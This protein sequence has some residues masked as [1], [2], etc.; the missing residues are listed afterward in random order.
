ME[1]QS[2]ITII[3]AY[4]QIVVATIMSAFLQIIKHRMRLTTWFLLVM[5]NTMGANS[6]ARSD[7]HSIKHDTTMG[8]VGLVFLRLHHC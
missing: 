6:G 8:D 7:K 2:Q 5:I 4:V 1:Y 3:H